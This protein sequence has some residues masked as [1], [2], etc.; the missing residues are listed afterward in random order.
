[1]SA[2]DDFRRYFDEAGHYRA[3]DGV[4]N[5][6]FATRGGGRFPGKLHFKGGLCVR[7]EMERGGDWVLPNETPLTGIR[8]LL[9]FG[10]EKLY[11]IAIDEGKIIPLDVVPGPSSKRDFLSN[12]RVARNL[13]VHPRVEA[14]KTSVPATAIQ[15]AL[16]R[17]DIWLTPKSVA[18][19]NAADIPEL[20]LDRQRE[21]QAAVQSF[22]A[23]AKQV[24]A[25]RPATA[26]QFGNASVAFAKIRQIL[27]PYLSLP[28][29]ARNIEKALRAVDFP[30]WVVNWDYE[31][32]SDS[33]GMAVVWVN[34]FVDEQTVPG[35]RLGRE[36]A[37]LTTKVR[38]A[39]ANF[40]IDRWH[41]I[42]LRTA[43]GHKVG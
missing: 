37:E 16:S 22:L 14:D 38:Q 27:E 23:V 33:D 36:A 25:D 43:V 2:V 3:G 15:G 20:G 40:K 35:T 5:V 24:P 31:I 32:G 9:H 41:H 4:V 30:A 39:F 8:F 34:M 42:R 7:A 10:E 18:G 26:E 17:A 21:L 11:G 1:M 19:F 6:T 13:F 29:E 12:F 28:D